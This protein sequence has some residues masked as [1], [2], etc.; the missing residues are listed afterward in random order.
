MPQAEHRDCMEC[1]TSIPINRLLCDK[2]RDGIAREIVARLSARL[3]AAAP[4]LD[5]GQK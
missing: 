1:G 5:R 4:A 3:E 2:C